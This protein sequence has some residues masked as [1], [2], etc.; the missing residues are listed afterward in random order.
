MDGERVLPLAETES[1]GYFSTVLVTDRKP[2]D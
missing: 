2:E 1:S